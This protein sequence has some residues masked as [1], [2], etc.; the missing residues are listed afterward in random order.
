M[1]TARE[2]VPCPYCGHSY[3]RRVK[4]PTVGEGEIYPEL[5]PCPHLVAHPDVSPHWSKDLLAAFLKDYSWRFRQLEIDV[6]TDVEKYEQRELERQRARLESIIRKRIEEDEK[7]Y[8][9]FF[10]KNIAD[11]EKAAGELKPILIGLKRAGS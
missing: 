4:L 6:E 10:R 2:E 3:T 5:S 7:G 8:G 1:T 9:F 11:M